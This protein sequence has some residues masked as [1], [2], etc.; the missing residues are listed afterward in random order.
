MKIKTIISLYE[1]QNFH[2]SILRSNLSYLYTKIKTDVE[3]ETANLQSKETSC[4]VFPDENCVAAHTSRVVVLGQNSERNIEPARQ[5]SCT[6]LC[7]PT[8]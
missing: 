5:P 6:L 7:L 8:G 1:D 2:I 3:L 4:K